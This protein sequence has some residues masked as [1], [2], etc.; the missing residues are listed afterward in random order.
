MRRKRWI[1]LTLAG[2]LALSLLGCGEQP[3]ESARPEEEIELLDPVSVEVT[4]QEAQ[5]RDIYDIRAY[6]ATVAP[7]V[8]EY[9]TEEYKTFYYNL[10]MTGQKVRKGQELFRV[11]V[12][13]LD[14]QIEKK[15]EYIASMEEDYQDF[16]KSMT[17]SMKQYRDEEGRW[18]YYVRI[19]EENEPEEFIWVPAEDAESSG[20]ESGENPG[21]QAGE[22]SGTEAETPAPPQKMVQVENPAHA[23]WESGYNMVMGRYRIAKHA[24]DTIQLQMDQR[25]A[26]Y[27]LDLA[28]QQYLLE[29]LRKERRECALASGMDGELVGMIERDRYSNY[30]YAYAEQPIAAVADPSRKQIQ[31]PYIPKNFID[32]AIDVYALINGQRYE[33]DY[34]AISQ[35]EYQKLLDRDKKVYT[36]F[37]LRDESV[38]VEN[39]QSVVIALVNNRYK[40]ALTVPK[41]SVYRDSTGQYVY[42]LQDKQRIYTSVEVAYSDEN[43]AVITSGL[44]VGDKVAYT[45][46]RPLY[47][48][49]TVVL[50]KGRFFEKY[51]SRAQITYD[52]WDYLRNTIEN[53]TVFFDEI[54]IRENQ[55]VKKGDV[56]AKVHVEP[57][58]LELTANETRLSRLQNRLADY[59]K[60]NQ[61]NEEEDFYLKTVKSYTEQIEDLQETIAEQKRDFSTTELRANIDCLV[62]S[63]YNAPSPGDILVP[64]AIIGSGVDVDYAYLPLNNDAGTLQYGQKIM[65]SYFDAELQSHPIVGRV[66][67]ATLVSV[68]SFLASKTAKVVLEPE[69]LAALIESI[70]RGTNSMQVPMEAELQVMENVVLVP[71][72]AV[73]NYSG[74]TYVYVKDEN[75]VVKMQNFVSGGNNR[76]YYWV[77]EGL[78]E[79]M[80]V[81]L[82]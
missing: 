9:S 46:E 69:D 23:E 6:Q 10:V 38:E 70:Y 3:K 66:A 74:K 61:G 62:W 73:H 80:E 77:L 75:G 35:E 60:D 16:V 81:C 64:N 37:T 27:E 13:Q 1:C 76:E 33:V 56:I 24:A 5:I 12:D 43:Y 72:E 17:K 78:T 19:N 30:Y 51:T 39:S 68:S 26:L 65:L 47:G 4:Y 50:Q 32:K 41:D 31:C 7:Y 8:E 52:S 18:N 36:T 48:D 22:D 55:Y 59:K 2:I 49:K 44:E 40:D 34:H 28:H 14:E 53:G 71:A 58:T 82:K 11:N 54:L 25:K 57:D 79:G 42:L 63:L 45:G 20:A 29:R 21:A 15:E 67:N